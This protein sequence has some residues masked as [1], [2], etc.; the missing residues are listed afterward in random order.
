MPTPEARGSPAAAMAA[1][2]QVG[3]LRFHLG[4]GR[5]IVSQPD[6]VALAGVGDHRPGG[7]LALALDQ[8]LEQP[9]RD[10]GVAGGRRADPP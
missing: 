3:E 6:G 7:M 8:V 1:A 9:E 10:H 2:Q 4:S 5:P